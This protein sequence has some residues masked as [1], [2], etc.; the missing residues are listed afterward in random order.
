MLEE[1]MRLIEHKHKK[2]KNQLLDIINNNVLSPNN[3]YKNTMNML[4][5]KTMINSMLEN[6]RSRIEP[7]DTNIIA[8]QVAS[9]LQKTMETKTKTK[10]E[11][12]FVKTTS[13]N[14]PKQLRTFIPISDSDKVTN[15]LLNIKEAI[16]NTL[17]KNCY[18]TANETYNTR[19]QLTSIQN[20]IRELRS[21]MFNRIDIAEHRS[22]I[23]VETIRQIFE[24]GGN[25]RLRKA[26]REGFGGKN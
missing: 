23:N 6:A 12:N 9:K 1:K 20:N 26:A 22:R 13:D 18:N 10:T 11:T 5:K 2:E 19:K 3:V 16:T 7:V 25:I 14:V 15:E 21:N 24:L 4:E 17:G 8:E